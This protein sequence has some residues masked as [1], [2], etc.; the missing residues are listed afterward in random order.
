MEV[1]AGMA[2]ADLY[3]QSSRLFVIKNEICDLVLVDRFL[4]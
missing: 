4:A 3:G 2:T 1:L